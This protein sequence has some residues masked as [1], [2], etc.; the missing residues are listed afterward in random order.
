HGHVGV[1]NELLAARAARAEDDADARAE[2]DVPTRDGDR[3]RQVLDEASGERDGLLAA[4]VLEQQRELVSAEPGD[5][6]A[7]AHD[8]LEPARDDPQE[9]VAG[10]VA[11]AVVDLL[12]AV[13]V[14]EE[15]GDLVLGARR[16]RKFVV[17]AV[18]EESAVGEAGEGVVERLVRQLL[19]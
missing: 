15:N 6:V 18:A 1:A 9:L 2:G 12:E 3:L 4:D 13:E 19:L 11:E 5:R 7:R 17:E 8:L 14:D 16:P 10:V